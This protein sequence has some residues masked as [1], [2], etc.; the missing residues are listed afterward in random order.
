MKQ[1]LKITAVTIFMFAMTSVASAQKVGHVNV[2]SLTKIWPAWKQVVDSI[3]GMQVAAQK[4]LMLMQQQYDQKLREIDSTKSSSS[5]TLMR[6][7]YTQLQQIEDNINGF[8]EIEG[9][10][11]QDYQ[12][13]MAD[14]LMKV[15]ND[16]ISRV[17]KAKGYT[18]VLDSSKGG[19]VLF[20]N[21]ADDIFVAVCAELKITIPAPKPKTPAPGGT[22]PK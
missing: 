3:S 8:A 12:I 6:L 13:R 19:Q 2:D 9:A 7:R 14:S 18:Y 21:P 17:A 4:Q 16:A 22:Q 20:A 11:L 5:E 10:R 15:M 1:L